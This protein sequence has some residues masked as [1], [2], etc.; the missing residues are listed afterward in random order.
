MQVPTLVSGFADR[1]VVGEVHAKAKHR[2]FW[3]PY[4]RFGLVQDR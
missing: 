3:V 4:S 1:V 2:V